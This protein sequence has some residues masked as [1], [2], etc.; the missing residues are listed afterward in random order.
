LA[1][2]AGVPMTDGPRRGIYGSVLP[3]VLQEPDP[4]GERIAPLPVHLVPA[5]TP[6]HQVGILAAAPA[7]AVAGEV[8][9]QLGEDHAG[10]PAS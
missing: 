3:L 7:V 1:A 10:V 6:H 8:Q 5:T 4:P 2:S 9:A